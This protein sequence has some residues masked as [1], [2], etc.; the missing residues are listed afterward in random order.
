MKVV[1][2]DKLEKGARIVLEGMIII[3]T[4]TEDV[5]KEATA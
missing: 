5:L 3:G 4:G 2:S 1:Y